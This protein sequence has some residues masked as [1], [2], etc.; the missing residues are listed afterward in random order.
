MKINNSH[1]HGFTLI[2]LIMVITLTG[3]VSVFISTITANQMQ[4]YIDVSVR[5]N[6]V[7]LAESSF[8]HI[9]RDVHNAVP[10]S[11][12]VSGT[13]LEFVPI[14]SAGR[15]RSQPSELSNSNHLDFS[16]ADTAF[17]VLGNFQQPPSGSQLV[18]YNFGWIDGSGPVAGANLYASA[19]TGVL[20]P[21]GSHVISP[22]GNNI[23][24]SDNGLNDL[25]SFDSG[26]QFSF[27]SPDKRFYVFNGAATYLCNSSTGEIKRYAG[28][29]VQNSQPVNASSAPLSSAASSALLVDHVESC[30]FNYSLNATQRFGI[31]TIELTLFD[32]GERIRLIHQIQV[33]N[34]A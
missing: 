7:N 11:V 20:S 24:V 14:V 25:I 15:Y 23:T 27:A 34:R 9:S 26:V 30:T 4:T 13:A 29:A 19:S 3:I 31:V 8:R 22:L 33:N 32:K 18:I 28:Y 5:T 10:N 6:L 17:Q 12:R 1:L 2:E 16:T 21:V